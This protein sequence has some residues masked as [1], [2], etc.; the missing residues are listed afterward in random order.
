MAI[1]DR[2]GYCVKCHKC[3]LVNRVVD[4]K[5]EVMFTAD[6]TE[7]EFLLDDGSKMRV[8]LCQTCKDNLT[9]KD[10][11]AIMESVIDGW[12]EEANQL[13]NWSQEKKDKYIERYSKRKIICKSEKL[14]KEHLDKKLAEF[15]EKKYGFDNKTKH[16]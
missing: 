12:K 10:I 6:H 1:P 16:L 4:M 7:T 5:M 11:P 8:C 13:T 14:E 2:Y 9:D 15:K 3:L